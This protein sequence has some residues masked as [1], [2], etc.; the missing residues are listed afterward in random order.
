MSKVKYGGASNAVLDYLR[1]NPNV[2]IP[3]VEIM[4]ALKYPDYTVSN[5]ITHLIS[6]GFPVTRPA[7]GQVLYRPVPEPAAPEKTTSQLYEYV[8]NTAGKVLVRDENKELYVLVPL[9]IFIQGEGL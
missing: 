5:G 6:K 7:R 3:H 1:Q 2:V 9:N 8:G 4:R